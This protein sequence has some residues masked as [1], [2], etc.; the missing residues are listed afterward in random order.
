M[1]DLLTERAAD[2]ALDASVQRVIE[3]LLEKL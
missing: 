1:V 3:V 2:P